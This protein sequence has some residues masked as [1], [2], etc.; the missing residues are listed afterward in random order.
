MWTLCRQP[1]RQL[2]YLFMPVQHTHYLGRTRIEGG[3]ASCPAVNP[4]FVIG[5]PALY[6]MPDADTV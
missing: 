4:T 5:F 6:V 1:G 3:K 2:K